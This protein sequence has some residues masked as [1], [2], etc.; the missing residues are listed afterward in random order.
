MR[1]LRVGV[2]VLVIG[3]SLFFATYLRVKTG[4][5][6][7]GASYPTALGPFLLEPRQTIIILN[8][9]SSDNV[10]IHVVCAKIWE[11]T[12]NVSLANPVFSVDGM[13]RL[14]SVT[15]Q[16]QKR[17]VYYFVVTTRD[18]RLVDEV[19]LKFEQTGLTQ[20]LY[21]TSMIAIIVGGAI[22]VYNV[23]RLLIKRKSGSTVKGENGVP[24]IES[25]R[26]SKIK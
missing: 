19:E 7:A 8:D 25:N 9:A 2:L 6:G 16:L 13:R 11:A 21:M 26:K 3:V 4:K 23:L 17:G 5:M 12:Q 20:D 15:F 1:M 22:A 24:F 14:Y 10:S 18:G